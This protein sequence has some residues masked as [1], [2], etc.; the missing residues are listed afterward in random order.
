M[1]VHQLSRTDARRIAVRAQLLDAERPDGLHDVVRG[2]SLL[3]IDP[4]AAVA[5]TADLVAWSRLGSSY[6]P[7]ELTAALERRTL[8]ELQAM[9]R[10]GEDL[11]LYRAE[12]AEWPERGTPSSWR[13]YHRGWVAAND[14]CRRDLLARLGEAGP[15]P[16]RALPDSCAEPW[17]SSGWSNNRNVTKLLELMVQRGE[18]AVAGRAGGDRLWDLA[19][20]VYPDVP[21]VPVEEALRIRDE[22]RLRALGIARARGPECQVEP[23][24]V[25]EAGEPAVVEGVRGSWRV[26]PAQLGRPFEGRAALLSPFDRLVHDRKRATE[27]FAYT[28][29][30]EMYKPAAKRRWGY[31]ALPIL[32]GDRLVGKLDATADRAA[33]R[34]RVAAVHQ[35]EPFTPAMSAAIGREIEDLASWLDLDLDLEQALPK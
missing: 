31:F 5:P 4:T 6:A 12:M 21:P 24:D 9:I 16:S 22:R 34:L 1:T 14:A 27:L 8:L 30:L 3:Q 2:L 32:H 33:G 7:A 20:R 13:E 18:V 17:R 29:Q 11:A 19:D 10:P 25:G 35:D 15:L 23:A 28:Y 26:D